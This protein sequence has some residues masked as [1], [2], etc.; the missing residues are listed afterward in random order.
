MSL[1]R[2]VVALTSMALA[3]VLS[4]GCS[5]RA[6]GTGPG[7]PYDGGAGDGA[8]PD[9]R[10]NPDGSPVNP[11]ASS[12]GPAELCGEMGDGN[13]LDDDCNGQVDETCPCSAT[14]V[15]RQ[16]FAGAPDRRNI[17]ACSD[18]VETCSEF[19]SWGPCV[20]GVSP[21]EEVCDGNDND[22]NG[23]SDDIA[24]C[25]SEVTCP[26]HDVSPPL[27]TYALRGERVYAG[28]ARSWSWRVE[29]PASVPAALC[30]SPSM[31]AA[32]DTDVYFTASGAYR[33]YVDVVTEDGTAASCGWTVYVQ[34]TGLRVEL[35]W[36]TMLD[37]RGGT[38][39]DLHLHRW[40]QNGVDTGWF[41]NDDCYY[42]NCTPIDGL[43]GIT[44]ADHAP[45]DISNCMDAPHG[46][47]AIW[48]SVG[49]CRNPR[50]DVDTNGIDGACE[51]SVTNP[52]DPAFC[53]PENINVDNPIAG[54]PYRVLVNYYSD[55]GYP[56]PTNVSVNIYCG[57]AIRASFGL[58]P[59]VTFT[60]GAEYGSFNESWIVADVVFVPGM[61]GTDC[62]V[63]PHG[64]FVR[65]G[66]KVLSFGPAWSCNYD[67][68]A[69]TCAPL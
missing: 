50:L 35:N 64:D 31:P 19:L 65:G 58:D 46:G 57:G 24:G 38:D 12:C 47:G 62:M 26:E 16:C 10:F 69:G 39:V 3:G 49:S 60:D 5:S 63:Y 61:C 36:D 8:A 29:C 7:S 43:E 22:C 68:S 37:T 66:D 44:W 9:A 14:G 2:A 33:V 32:M 48:R 11:C 45:S 42:G 20:G 55:S 4:G 34:G 56:G 59:L 52:S 40:T 30:P 53:A 18:G 23:V 25:T 17:G 21:G 41:T 6:R 27:S 51:S 54:M 15:T 67:A 28:A 1:R 13:G